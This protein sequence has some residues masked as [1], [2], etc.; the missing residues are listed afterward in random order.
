[1][2]VDLYVCYGCK[3]NDVHGDDIMRCNRCCETW[4]N[5]DSCYG[6]QAKKWGIE[7]EEDQNEG[8]LKYC[9][10]C[11]TIKIDFEFEYDNFVKY[12]EGLTPQIFVE[13]A[14]EANREHN[15]GNWDTFLSDI[16]PDLQDYIKKK[17]E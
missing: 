17:E 16:I 10:S 6:E 15:Y 9:D 13:F 1:M 8:V 14:S 3:E 2:G 5:Y 11:M 12:C 4:C 7:E